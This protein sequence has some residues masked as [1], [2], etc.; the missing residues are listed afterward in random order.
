MRDAAIF[1]MNNV[2]YCC[3]VIFIILFQIHKYLRGTTAYS[4]NC[5]PDTKKKKTFD[6]Q[7]TVIMYCVRIHRTE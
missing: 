6:D 1:V 5:T 2:Q 7:V 4:H 3:S